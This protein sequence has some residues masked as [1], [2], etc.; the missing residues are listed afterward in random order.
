MLSVS[1]ATSAMI[2]LSRLS[3][4]LTSSGRRYFGQ[5]T[6]WYLHEK[7]MLRVDPSSIQ[8]YMATVYIVTK[9][10]AAKAKSFARAFR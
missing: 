4:P 5:K 7:A 8:Q 9:K 10:G 2:R 1:S 3:T 6:T